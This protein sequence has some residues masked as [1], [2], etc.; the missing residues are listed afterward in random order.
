MKGACERGACKDGNVKG[1]MPRGP[2]KGGHVSG[3]MSQGIT[4][5]DLHAATCA[6]ASTVST[7]VRRPLS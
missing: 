2:C 4:G 6:K 1:A 5:P 7:A 3:D